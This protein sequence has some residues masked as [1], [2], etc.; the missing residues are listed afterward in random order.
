MILQQLRP[1]YVTEQY[2]ALFKF[3]G[4]VQ[5]RPVVNV[6]VVTGVDPLYFTVAGWLFT[7][8]DNV[9]VVIRDGVAGCIYKVICSAVV[10]GDTYTKVGT[11]SVLPD[12]ALEP[13]GDVPVPDASTMSTPLYPALIASQAS[14]SVTIAGGG[15]VG[16]VTYGS[17][18]PS[19]VSLSATIS[20]GTLSL[21]APPVIAPDHVNLEVSIASGKMQDPS[22]GVFLDSVNVVVAITAGDMRDAPRGLFINDADVTVTISGGSLYVP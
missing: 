5:G 18:Q 20:G 17:S 1:K 2:A 4:T 3:P 22:K 7:A 19:E 15:L 12:D 13:S 11:L 8:D 9:G 21:V 10:G 14:A 16:L 6:E